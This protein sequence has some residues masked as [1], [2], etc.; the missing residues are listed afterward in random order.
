MTIEE[1]KLDYSDLSQQGTGSHEV[2]EEYK[3]VTY[4]FDKYEIKVKLTLSDEFVG[5]TEVKVNKE[6]LSHKQKAV[7]SGF[8]DVEELYED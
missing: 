6:F 3:I 7:S 8:H 4:P 5:I 1:T 2:N